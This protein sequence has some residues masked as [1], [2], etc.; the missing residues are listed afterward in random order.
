MGKRKDAR[1]AERDRHG[2]SDTRR[3]RYEDTWR[4]WRKQVKKCERIMA[5]MRMMF[6]LPPL[7]IDM[8][9]GW[10]VDWEHTQLQAHEYTA[11]MTPKA[12]RGMRVSAAHEFGARDM[13]V[14]EGHAAIAEVD[15]LAALYEWDDE[16][17][18]VAYRDVYVRLKQEINRVG[19]DECNLMVCADL[20]AHPVAFPRE[21][22]APKDWYSKAMFYPWE[23]SL[24][25]WEL[26][27]DGTMRLWSQ[28]LPVE[29]RLPN[30]EVHDKFARLHGWTVP[31][32]EYRGHG[33]GFKDQHRERAIKEAIELVESGLVP[34][35]MRKRGRPKVTWLV[36]AALG[37]RGIKSC[38][39]W[40][41]MHAPD[42]DIEAL[43]DTRYAHAVDHMRVKL[44][45]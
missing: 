5:T 43:L 8:P 28:G 29:R 41:D 21:V 19:K 44:E 18:R 39:Y 7:R 9:G 1:R 24:I 30:Q 15:F 26:M 37:R 3:S 23:R 20:M 35:P 4:A 27:D 11:D 16:Q 25:A 40:S 22:E 33:D 45:Q 10:G 2:I 34:V 13:V 12:S 14:Q 42:A 6:G 38:E 36:L 17:V 32:L 31:G